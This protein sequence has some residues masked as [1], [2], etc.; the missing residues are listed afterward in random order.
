MRFLSWSMLLL[1]LATPGFA[2]EGDQGASSATTPAANCGN[3]TGELLPGHSAHGDAFNEG[4]RQAAVL[5]QG[6]GSTVFPVTTTN[7]E[8]QKFMSQGVAQLHGFWYFE[9]ERSFRQAAALDPKC[10]MAYWGMAMA[11]TNNEKRAKGFIAEAVKRKEGLSEREKLYID[12]LD[13]YYKADAG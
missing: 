13:A 10:G 5:M 2:A 8:A 1:G 6:M 12:A 4:P 3:A 9:A 7:G 11:N